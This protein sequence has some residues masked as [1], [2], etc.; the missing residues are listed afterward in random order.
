LFVTASKTTVF[1]ENIE[2]FAFS[3]VMNRQGQFRA[4]DTFFETR[5]FLYA[6][7]KAFTLELTIT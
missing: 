3:A 2:D 4:G 5:P 6:P 7:P 1:R